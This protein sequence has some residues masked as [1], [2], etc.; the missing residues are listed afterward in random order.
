M[1]KTELTQQAAH[2][3]QTMKRRSFTFIGATTLL[4]AHL[5]I[6][7][8]NRLS[9]EAVHDLFHTQSAA[10]VALLDDVMDFSFSEDSDKMIYSPAIDRAMNATDQA[11][12]TM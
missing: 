3:I 10:V 5:T 2:F 9:R 11:G 8:A 4:R 12:R 6:A 7:P 1:T